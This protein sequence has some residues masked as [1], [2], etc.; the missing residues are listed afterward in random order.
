MKE[1]VIEPW[2]ASFVE[3]DNLSVEHCLPL[4]WRYQALSQ[5]RE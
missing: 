1:Q 4:V 3:T 2:L 5:I